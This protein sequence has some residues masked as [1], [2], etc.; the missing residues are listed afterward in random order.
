MDNTA[1]LIS[2]IDLTSLNTD[3]TENSITHLC[4][5]A[6]T[7][8]GNVAAVCIYPQFISL[9][10]SLVNN[11]SVKIATVAN[12]PQ[13]NSDIKQVAQAVEQALQAGVD[14]VDVVIPYRDCLQGN[15]QTSE[16]LVKT[17]KQLCRDHVLKVILETGELADNKLIYQVS[18]RMLEQGA[19]FIKTSTGKVAIGATVEAATAMLQA[20]KAVNPAAGFK[21]SGGVRTPEQ[22]QTYFN[23]ASQIMGTA[24]CTSQHLRIGAS[25]LLDALLQ[26]SSNNSD[27]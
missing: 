12:F 25:S 14:E 27:Y 1:Q 18:C 20:I 3:D 6:F 7:S 9:A 17:C 23:L 5:Q 8:Q 22:A 15:Y 2:L 21:A 19:D 10:K 11:T 26:I 4:Q 13:G 16:L 24:W